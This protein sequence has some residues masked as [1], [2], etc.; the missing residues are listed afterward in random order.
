M[1]NLFDH[2]RINEQLAKA[3]SLVA[4]YLRIGFFG[5]I[6]TEAMTVVDVGYCWIT[7]AATTLKSYLDSSEAF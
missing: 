6:I 3:L 5:V 2:Y 7:S 4:T 1:K